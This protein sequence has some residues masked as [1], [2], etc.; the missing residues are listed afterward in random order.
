MGDTRYRRGNQI[1]FLLQ[2]VQGQAKLIYE[3]KVRLEAR[4]AHEGTFWRD[5]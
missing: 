3:D 1:R 5:G 4:K 2:E